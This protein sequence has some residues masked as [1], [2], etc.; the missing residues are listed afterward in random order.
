MISNQVVRVNKT[1]YGK[2]RSSSNL[3]MNENNEGI[4]GA[5]I[6]ESKR[7]NINSDGSKFADGS[8]AITT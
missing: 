6:V 1:I 2:Q 3:V 7:K 8:V 5:I 4:D